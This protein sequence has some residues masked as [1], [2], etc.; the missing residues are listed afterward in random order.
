MRLIKYENILVTG[1]I[2][3][4]HLFEIQNLFAKPH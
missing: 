1:Y 2:K 3:N 4:E